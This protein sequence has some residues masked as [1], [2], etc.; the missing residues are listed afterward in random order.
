MA[1]QTQ[2]FAGT[3]AKKIGH[4]YEQMVC[5]WLNTKKEGHY[6]DGKTKT[7]RDI[8]NANTG[9]SYSLKSVGKNHTQCHLTSTKRWCEF[10]SI[11]GDTRLWFDLFFGIPKE[12][13]SNGSNRQHRLSKSEIDDDLNDLGLDWFNDNKN[14]I[15]DVIVRRGMYPTP[16]D[17]LIWL[18][19]P[20]G[21]TQIYDVNQLERLVDH[22]AWF[23]NETTLHF[24]N[25]N[26]EKMFHLQMKGSGTKYTSGYHSMMFHIYKCF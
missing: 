10:F 5:D 18:D 23:M 12:D 3:E 25:T 13:V 19:K 8:I 6:I 15:F 21:K 17:Y 22:G 2:V 7:K 24:M 14:N 4:L 9:I 1:T 16:V 20:T 11:E 26:D